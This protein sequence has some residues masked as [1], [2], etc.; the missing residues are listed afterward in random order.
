M[1]KKELRLFMVLDIIEFVLAVIG[2]FG[3]TFMFIALQ[4]DQKYLFLI[5][6]LYV[7]Y[8]FIKNWNSIDKYFNEIKLEKTI[9]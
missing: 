5:C 6:D 3:F 9:Q 2:I 1:N 4:N 8:V 7:I